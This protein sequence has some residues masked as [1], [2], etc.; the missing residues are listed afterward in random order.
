MRSKTFKKVERFKLTEKGI[1]SALAE[2]MIIPEHVSVKRHILTPYVKKELIPPDLDLILL[3]DLNGFYHRLNRSFFPFLS[4]FRG[5]YVTENSSWVPQRDYQKTNKALQRE[6][7][8]SVTRALLLPQER[9][10]YWTMIHEALHDTFNHLSSE[11]RAQLVQSVSS[12][13][14][15]CG[16]LQNMLDLTHLNITNFDWDVDAV[17]RKM[18]E[19]RIARRSLLDGIDEFYTFPKLNPLDQLQVVDEFISNFFANDRG[20][21]RWSP[22]HLHPDFRATLRE[23]GYNV[24]SPPEVMS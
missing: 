22:K 6:Y 2:R 20:F 3:E 19:N 21:D 10:D 12:A 11:K 13:Y 16:K 14:D 4:N 7:G 15:M 1:P 8:I 18:D 17:A 5:S 9:I 24:D 23:V